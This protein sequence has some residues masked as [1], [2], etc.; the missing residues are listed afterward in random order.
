MIEDL[1]PSREGQINSPTRDL[2]PFESIVVWLYGY[3]SQIK[4]PTDCHLCILGEIWQNCIIALHGKLCLIGQR[5][6]CFIILTNSTKFASINT[7]ENFTPLIL[8]WLGLTFLFRFCAS[9]LSIRVIK[10][11][12]IDLI[13]AHVRSKG[14]IFICLTRAHGCTSYVSSELI[15]PIPVSWYSVAPDLVAS[16]S[17]HEIC[18]PV[19]ISNSVYLVIYRFHVSCFLKGEK[20]HIWSR[21]SS[22]NLAPTLHRN[23]CPS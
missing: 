10:M 22:G 16:H 18:G 2:W 23:Y 8:C 9:A 13:T 11:I 1:N 21:R 15:R 5:G 12:A 17:C 20:S 4:Q 6:H 14:G 19:Q 3:R 7:V